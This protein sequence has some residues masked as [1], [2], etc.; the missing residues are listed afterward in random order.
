MEEVPPQIRAEIEALEEESTQQKGSELSVTETSRNGNVITVKTIQ[1]KDISV[2]K[3][4]DEFGVERTYRSLNEMPP[5]IRVA[6]E[7]AEK[8]LK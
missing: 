5:E 8:K 2:Y 1:Q 7:E 6:I 3:I 4:V